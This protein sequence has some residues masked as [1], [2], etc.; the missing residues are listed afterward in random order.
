MLRTLQGDGLVAFVDGHRPRGR[1]MVELEGGVGGGGGQP[2]QRGFQADSKP[3][4]PEALF[5][6]T[7]LLEHNTNANEEPL[8]NW[9]R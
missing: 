5:F 3:L 2:T 7:S 8:R 6:V 1:R 9:R 4:R